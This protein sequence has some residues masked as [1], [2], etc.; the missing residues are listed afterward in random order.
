LGGGILQD[1]STFAIQDGRAESGDGGIISPDCLEKKPDPS[2][3]NHSL[4]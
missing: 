2:G 1:I 4:L 3:I